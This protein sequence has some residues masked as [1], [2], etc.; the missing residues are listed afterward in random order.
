MNKKGII[1]PMYKKLRNYARQWSLCGGGGGRGDK[2]N[3]SQDVVDAVEDDV[4]RA[5]LAL[6]DE[7]LTAEQETRLGEAIQVCSTISQPFVTRVTRTPQ[8]DCLLIQL[9]CPCDLPG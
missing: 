2:S 7:L 1:P 6:S 9:V 3:I 8:S 4:L 5:A